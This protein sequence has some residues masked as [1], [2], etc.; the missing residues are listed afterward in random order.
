MANIR[1]L[2]PGWLKREGAAR[3]SE[4]REPERFEPRLTEPADIGAA[5][6]KLE[7]WALA[8]SLIDRHPQAEALTRWLRDIASPGSGRALLVIV[9]G[10]HFD[11]PDY[12][13]AR[14]VTFHLRE[15]ID[16]AWNNLGLVDWHWSYDI[17]EVLEKIGDRIRAPTDQ[18]ARD[19]DSLNRLLSKD[20]RC[21]CFYH[22]VEGAHWK[23]DQGKTALREWA[24]IFAQKRLTLRAEQLLIAFLGLSFSSSEAVETARK[25]IVA[26]W[27]DI[28]S[29]AAPTMLE[30]PPLDKVVRS[31]LLI[32]R[33]EASRKLQL[34]ESLELQFQGEIGQ[35]FAEHEEQHMET[36]VAVLEPLLQLKFQTGPR[37]V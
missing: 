18:I 26:V 12:F 37:F 10:L 7:K 9:P 31:D 14:C 2:I 15:N 35:L 3:R 27:N 23:H 6:S 21:V 5:G 36:I 34:K 4:I 11:C 33:A 25:Q 19:V 8:L 1:G 28:E 20:G 24:R 30:M 17:S 13:L 29:S 16:R 32:W 22:I